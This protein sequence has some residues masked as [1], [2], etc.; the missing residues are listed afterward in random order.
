MEF[1]ILDT[2]DADR[3]AHKLDLSANAGADFAVPLAE[4][5]ADI[6]RIEKNIFSSG[7]RYGGGSWK[8]LSPETIRRKQGR[9]TILRD[10]DALYNSVTEP[11]A[12]FQILEVTPHTLV[13]GTDRPWAAVHQ[14]GSPYVRA[15]PFIRFLP[16]DVDRWSR[17]LLNH[18]VGRFRA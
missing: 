18:V 15:R 7:G 6:F 2:G 11:G 8:K 3:F 5:E 12:Q 10:T 4:I 13:F 1:I 9:T 14:Y 16:S 17:M